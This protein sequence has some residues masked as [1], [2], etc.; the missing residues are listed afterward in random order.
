M[1]ASGLKPS[2]LAGI[3]SRKGFIRVIWLNDLIPTIRDLDEGLMNMKR[4]QFFN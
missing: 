3:G 4:A 2:I 1:E